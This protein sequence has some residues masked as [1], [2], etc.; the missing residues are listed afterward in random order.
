MGCHFLLKGIFQTQGLNPGLPH[1]DQILY[2]LSHQGSLQYHK[3]YL[4]KV[5]KSVF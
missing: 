2:H 1:Y 3:A 4:F 5:Y